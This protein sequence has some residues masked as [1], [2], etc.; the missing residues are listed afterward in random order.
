MRLRLSGSALKLIACAAMLIDHIG[1]YLLRGHAWATTPLVSILGHNYS[2]F[3]LCRIIGRI[4]FPIFAFMIVEGFKHTRS[5]TRYGLTLLA[6]AVLTELPWNLLRHGTLFFPG[7][8][9]VLWTL[10]AGFLALCAYE[11]LSGRP[12]LQLFSVAGIY[13]VI[14]FSHSDYHSVG[15]PFIIMLYAMEG[16]LTIQAISAAL[17]LP[18]RPFAAL[19]YI[20]L[21]LYNGKRGFA[22]TRRWCKY[23]FYAFY[24]AH[25]LAIWLIKV[26]Q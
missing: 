16:K 25:I 19:A 8:Q 24:P 12:W 10:L 4:A 21:S 23:A 14:Y 9:N 11:R 6:F 18:M 22:A 2:W 7:S 26:L 15:L 17:V 1:A 13:A 5:R 20:P 3:S